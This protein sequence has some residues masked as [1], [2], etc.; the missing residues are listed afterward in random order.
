MVR[1]NKDKVKKLIK[2]RLK[3]KHESMKQGAG[4]L[5]RQS[6]LAKL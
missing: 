3:K 4:S 2:W 5:K 6:R 1:N